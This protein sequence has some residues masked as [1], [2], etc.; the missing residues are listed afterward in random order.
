MNERERMESVLRAGLPDLGLTLRDTQIQQLL[1]FGIAVLEQNRVMN[2]TAVKEPEA[3]ARLHL[4]DSLS[5]LA[6]AK[7]DGLSVLDVGTG[8]GFPGVPLK[9]ACP[10]LN[11]TLLDSTEKKIRWL[12]R[13]LPTLGIA[14][15]AV[16][17]RAEEFAPQFDVVT[18]R[19]V[20]RLPLLCEL[21]Q[22]RLH[23]G[24]WFYALKGA[25]GE[26]EASE[27]AG[28]IHILG[29]T[30]RKIETLTLPGGEKRVLIA[31]EQ[32]RPC[33]AGYPRSWGQIK[34]RPLN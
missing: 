33:P 30:I 16:S 34:K 23:P 28:A 4:L 27:A 6:I 24:G 8:A 17:A 15:Q 11:L 29:G 26:L 18:S 14:A 7:L 3:F 20:A 5:L 10:S 32:T 31:I 25:E 19:A 1:D 22:P 2:L 21:C 9:I 13:I 12:N